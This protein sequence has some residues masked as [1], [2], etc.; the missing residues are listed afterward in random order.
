MSLGRGRGRGVEMPGARW[1]V[2]QFATAIRADILQHGLDATCAKCAFI[3][4]Y[5]RL[6]GVRRQGPADDSSP[7]EAR[8]EGRS[9]ASD[10]AGAEARMRSSRRERR[11]GA[12]WAARRALAASSSAM[13]AASHG[14]P[15]LRGGSTAS[16]SSALRAGWALSAWLGSCKRWAPSGLVPPSRP[17]WPARPSC[18]REVITSVPSAVVDCNVLVERFAWRDD[19][20]RRLGAPRWIW[21]QTNPLK[22]RLTKLGSPREYMQAIL[23]EIRNPTENSKAL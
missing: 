3:R 12:T 13:A 2:Q 20:A 16:I 5:P 18:R 6:G 22:K 11:A 19:A 1:P 7:R 4:A 17:R 21:A 10:R 23:K 15:S 8:S 9:E 14:C